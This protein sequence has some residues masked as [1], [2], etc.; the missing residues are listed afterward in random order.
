MNEGYTFRAKKTDHNLIDLTFYSDDEMVYESK[1]YS[2]DQFVSQMIITGKK[3]LMK[4][5]SNKGYEVHYTYLNNKINEII[6]L[7]HQNGF[8]LQI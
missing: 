8:E 7:A 1:G 2:I 6:A 5:E 4:I 3:L